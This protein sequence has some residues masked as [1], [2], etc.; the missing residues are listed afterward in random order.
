MY[1]GKVLL[2]QPKQITT[3]VNKSELQRGT[4]SR[5]IFILS[6][7]FLIFL[8]PYFSLGINASILAYTI[9]KQ[10]G[11]IISL[12]LISYKFDKSNPL[13]KV[14]CGRNSQGCNKILDSKGNSIW[15]IDYSEIGFTY[16]SGTLLA[17]YLISNRSIHAYLFSIS[18]LSVPF[19]IYSI[20]YQAFIAKHWCRLC[21]GIITILSL[22]ILITLIN[23]QEILAL[24]HIDPLI[25]IDLFFLFLAIALT[26]A[27]TIPLLHNTTN[28][29]FYKKA[30]KRLLYKPEVFQGLLKNQ[31]IIIPDN[32]FQAGIQLGNP[33]AQNTLL[34][35]CN[36][37]CNPCAKSHPEIMELLKRFPDKLRVVIMY[38]N[39][40]EPSGQEEQTL[41]H[42][43][44]IDAQK[45]TDVT[46]NALNS[47]YGNL[48]RDYNTFKSTFP[49]EA[50]DEKAN[51]R[52]S[53]MT[54]WS[55]KVGIS[56]TPTYFLNNHELPSYYN[57]N[58]LKHLL[59]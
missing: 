37:Y 43:L 50:F 55:T 2:G 51:L 46:I 47:W 40:S 29:N 1:S 26:L 21:L 59:E 4:K 16:F 20:S 53:E 48:H 35:V 39:L 33:N 57:I 8:K 17:L 15:G 58:D 34:K 10:L 6:L 42:L 3:Q 13:A 22:E 14:L 54:E 36:L 7:A 12:I 5:Q 44:T 49:I 11:C 38:L 9:L 31:P 32:A 24:P 23:F 25:I 52:I 30:F 41:L 27:I 45:N 19:I 18:L 28:L 56:H